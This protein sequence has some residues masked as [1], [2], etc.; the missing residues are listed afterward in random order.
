MKSGPKVGGRIDWLQ[1]SCPVG[2]R[3]L[4]SRGQKLEVAHMWADWQHLPCHPRG[5]QR[6]TA[7]DEIRTPKWAYWLRH[8]CLLGS[9]PL[10]SG[11]PNH[12]WPTNRQGG[13]I[14]PA[15]W[16][17]PTASERGT[18]SKVAHKWARW[19]QPLRAG[20]FPP[21]QCGGHNQRWPR[22]RQGGYITPATWGVPT[23]SERGTK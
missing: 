12:N 15:A 17:V 3:T 8:P 6:F 10:Q 1:H 23:A 7:G 21:L 18:Q 19:L 14:T 4:Q 11:A 9:T 22:S 2:A 13:Y 20:G 16:G 5:P